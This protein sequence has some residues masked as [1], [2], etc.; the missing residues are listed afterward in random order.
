MLTHVNK[1]IHMESQMRAIKTENTNYFLKNSL[2]LHNTETF[3]TGTN[4]IL[5]Y[6]KRLQ[7][8]RVFYVHIRV[9]TY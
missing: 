4:N 2:V 8:I 9:H 5:T 3:D 7:L 1:L 6:V